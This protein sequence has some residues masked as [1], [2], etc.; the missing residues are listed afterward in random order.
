MTVYLVAQIDVHE[1]R[2]FRLYAERSPAIVAK[3]GGQ[4]L[5]RGGATQTLEGN[6]DN[7]RTVI[8][9][10]PS[11]ENAQAFYHSAEYQ[12]AKAIRETAANAQ[13]IVVEGVTS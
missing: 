9:E 11:M 8:V 7:R 12:E 10:F 2:A 1:P 4:F 6:A 5:V 13:L 3:Y